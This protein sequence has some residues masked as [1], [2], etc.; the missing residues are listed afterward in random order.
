M[1][2]PEENRAIRLAHAIH[3]PTGIYR[4]NITAIARSAEED[5]Q[6]AGLLSG[7]YA[8]QTGDIDIDSSMPRRGSGRRRDVQQR[9]HGNEPRDL[10]RQCRPPR[11]GLPERQVA[12]RKTCI[13]CSPPSPATMTPVFAPG[14][15]SRPIAPNAAEGRKEIDH[16]RA[17]LQAGQ[18]THTTGGSDLLRAALPSNRCRPVTSLFLP[19]HDDHVKGLLAALAI[20]IDS[21]FLVRSDA[22]VAKR[23]GDPRR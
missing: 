20:D 3:V 15:A 7:D 9:L 17:G 21:I 16:R 4:L 14:C 18:I 2:R 19:H 12:A 10:S 8:V 5:Q 11:R 13:C 6:R 1:R 23:S 22:H